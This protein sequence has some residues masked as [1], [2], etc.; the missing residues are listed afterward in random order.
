MT[1]FKRGP[2]HTYTIITPTTPLDM[3]ETFLKDKDD[4]FAISTFSLLSPKCSFLPF[5]FVVTD[6]GRNFVLGVATREDLEVWHR[7]IAWI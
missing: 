2:S 5:A 7:T 6:F 4:S 3:L 1:R